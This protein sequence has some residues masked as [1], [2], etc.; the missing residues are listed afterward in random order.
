M[1]LET[2]F[3]KA[4]LDK[5]RLRNASNASISEGPAHS[6]RIMVR[7]AEFSDFERV[8]ALNLRLGQGP[9]S[10]ENWRRLWRDNPALAA[11]N[12]RVPIG[13]LLESL[14][15]IV[16]FLGNVPLQCE[17]GG[18]IVQTAATCRFAVDPAHRA[19]SHLLVMSFFRQKNVDL[20]L[21]TTAT[22]AAAKI[23]T[24]LKASPM[25]QAGYGT[26]LFWVLDSRQFAKAVLGKMGMQAPLRGAASMLGALALKTDQI[27]RGRLPRP[28]SSKE[29]RIREMRVRE[30]GPEF[31]RLWSD[32]AQQSPDLR[33]SRSRE[34]MRWHFEPPENRRAVVVL[35][36]YSGGDL[37][38]YTVVRHEPAVAGEFRRSLVAD[39]I[40]R[41]DTSDAV[42]QLLA[43]AYR[44]AREAGCHALEVMGFPDRIRRVAYHWK[45]YVRRYPAHPYFFKARDQHLHKVLLNETAWY[46]CPFDGD[47][48]LWP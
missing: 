28:A 31:D 34:I 19:F 11:R 21:N 14:H 17:F 32:C 8:S 13:W 7:E 25:P 24:A 26:V 44:N 43:A 47:A 5:I 30:M 37:I 12:E 22:P 40:V 29:Y 42:E 48:T 15:G 38:G 16:G 6:A 4:I 35:G 46:A 3:G 9:D 33:A 2:K 45:P 27:S 36:C 10:I 18:S 23:M 41:H 20:F 39:L 1:S